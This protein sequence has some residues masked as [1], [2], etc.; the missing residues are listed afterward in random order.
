MSGSHRFCLSLRAIASTTFFSY[1]PRRPTAPGSSPPWPG[2]IATVIRR[3]GVLCEAPADGSDRAASRRGAVRRR[4]RRRR[5]GA[6]AVEQRHQRIERHTRIQIED[7]PVAELRDGLQ[8]EHLRPDLGFEIEHDAQ[9]AARRLA[10]A[11]RGDVRVRRLHA[12]REGRELVGSLDAREIEHEPARI[13]EHDELMLDRCR[14]F[15]DDARVFLRGPQPR[16]RDPRCVGPRGRRQPLRGR[17][18]HPA[19]RAPPLD[20]HATSASQR[21]ALRERASGI[22]RRPPYARRRRRRDPR[23]RPRRTAINARSGGGSRSPTR[24]GHS[25]RQTA[26]SRK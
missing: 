25:T 15:E 9:E 22:A 8:R 16:R 2:S 7:E 13:A 3:D 12:R 4:R 19:E 17:Q 11:N 20:R 24:S 18:Q 5:V 26:S 6:L 23:R 14:R 10:D 1:V 21:F